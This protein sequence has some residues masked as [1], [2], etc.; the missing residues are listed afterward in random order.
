MRQKLSVLR[1]CRRVLRPGGRIAFLTIE[2]TPG[3]NGTDRRRAHRL[4]PVAV[5]V[6]TSY[7]SLL[8]TAGFENVEA[9]DL[10]GE[11]LATQRLWIHA[12]DR[13][14]TEIREIMGADLFDD[15]LRNRRRTLRA[16]EEGLLARVLYT[17]ARPIVQ[18]NR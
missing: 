9:T 18:R 6:P 13:R 2:P 4:G 7:P 16:I 1:A 17:A 3:L 10:T 15:R 5:A 12:T 11:Y 8:G 14:A